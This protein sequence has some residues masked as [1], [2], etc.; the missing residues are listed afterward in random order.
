M[1]L[2]WS[3]QSLSDRESI[4][5]YISQD[6]P[7][8]AIYLDDEFETCATLACL[9]P[10]MHRTGRVAGTREIIVHPHY[11]MFYRLKKDELNILRVL[12][13]AQLWP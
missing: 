7:V 4:L 3:K 6:D 9:H 11:E 8:A 10:E 2:T 12:H 13:T 5:D 1:R